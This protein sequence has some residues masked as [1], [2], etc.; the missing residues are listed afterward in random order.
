MHG[1]YNLKFKIIGQDV[2]T[3]TYSYVG[4]P[5]SAKVVVHI[6]STYTRIELI[7]N[8]CQMD[9]QLKVCYNSVLICT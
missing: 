3:K 8:W 1:P 2:F 4:I 6:V 7:K 5:V 9:I